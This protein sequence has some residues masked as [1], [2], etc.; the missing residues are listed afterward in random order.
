MPGINYLARGLPG[1]SPLNI[2]QR[3]E[4]IVCDIELHVSLSRKLNTLV[5]LY[6]WRFSRNS[7]PIHWL[8]HD[9]MTSS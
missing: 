7:V 2:V 6:S 4:E 3:K 1:S 8:V 5:L 9:L